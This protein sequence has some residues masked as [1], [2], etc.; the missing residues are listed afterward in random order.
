MCVS[1]AVRS[2][3]CMPNSTLTFQGAISTDFAEA[4]VQVERASDSGS[5]G[6]GFDY[7]RWSCAESIS[8]TSYS[9][10]PQFTQS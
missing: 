6:L 2:R 8:Q 4:R 5:E 3:Y 7:Q 10:F 9:A 1:Y